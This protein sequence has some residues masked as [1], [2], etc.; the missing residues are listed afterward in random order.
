MKHVSTLLVFFFR[1]VMFNVFDPTETL[2][3]D[4]DE[5]LLEPAV[6]L[7]NA[8]RAARVPLIIISGRRSVAV[9]TDVGGAFRSQHLHGRAIDVQV[10]GY[11]REQ[12]PGWWWNQ[13]G[14]YGEWLGLR[15]GGRFQTRDV[16][17]FDLGLSV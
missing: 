8:A 5:D 10:M 12:I 16:N 14:A 2:L 7:V 11:R 1:L 17:H 15:W 13:L 4:L 6:R 9:N 3:R